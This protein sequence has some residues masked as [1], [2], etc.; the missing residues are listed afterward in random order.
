MDAPSEVTPPPTPPAAA[1]RSYTFLIV[2]LFLV[3]LAATAAV[4]WATRP[5]PSTTIY[6]QSNVVAAGFRI[7]VIHKLDP[8]F[9]DAD[10]DLLADVPTDP[11]KLIDPP[12]LEFSFIAVEDPEPYKKRWKGFCDYLSKE[13][14]KPVEYLSVTSNNEEM[15]A[16]RDGK[17]HVAAFNTGGVPPAVNECG[18]I[19]ICAL[20]SGDTGALTH[21]DIIVPSDSPLQKVEDLKGHELTLTSPDSNSGCKA[22]LV[23]LRANFGMQGVA[24][25]SLRYSSSHETSIAGIASHKYEAAAVASDMLG[26]QIAAGAITPGQFRTIYESESFPTAGLGY[27]YN[28]KPELAKKIRDALL[29]FDWAGTPL[30]KDLSSSRQTKFVPINYKND[31]SLIRRIDDEMGAPQ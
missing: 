3:F 21:T 24:D 15:A 9:T 7:P 16:M 2:S 10:G 20:P 26:R 17:L 12:T 14:G 1:K 11:S 22:P 4:I 25:F 31:W 30:E 28:L 27:V 13:T 6:Q 5:P 19:P 18:F 23:L 29:S 8:K